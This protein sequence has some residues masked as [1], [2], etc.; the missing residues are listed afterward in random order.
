MNACSNLRL[1]HN[2]FNNYEFCQK[3]IEKRTQRMYLY[4]A[5]Y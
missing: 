5:K 1:R 2:T 3:R 4:K